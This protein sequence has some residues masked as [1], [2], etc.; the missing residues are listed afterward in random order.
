MAYREQL[1]DYRARWRR[2]SLITTQHYLFFE[3]RFEWLAAAKA[4]SA[5]R[6]CVVLDWRPAPL[7][8]RLRL[9][10]PPEFRVHD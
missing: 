8:S 9:R 7:R 5:P 10:L 1:F 3:L 4:N 6:V 2:S